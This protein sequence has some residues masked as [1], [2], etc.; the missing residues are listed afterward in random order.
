MS[1][2]V[3]NTL[4]QK[5]SLGPA[6]VSSE[7]PNGRQTVGDGA[8]FLD[9][10][11]AVCHVQ[12]ADD[13]Y[14]YSTTF[15]GGPGVRSSGCV[16]GSPASSFF[17]SSPL[18]ASGQARFYHPNI[19]AD[20]AYPLTPESTPSEFSSSL[21][22]LA[23]PPGVASIPIPLSK[24]F[25]GPPAHNLITPPYTPEDIE[26]RRS[27]GSI[28]S[29]QS[30]A[31]LDFLTTLFPRSGLAALPHA[32][33]VSITSPALEAIWEGIVLEMPGS[34][35]TLFVHGKGAEHVKLRESI[36]ALLDLAD[37]HLECTAFVIALERSSPALGELLHS[38][39]YVGGTVVTKPPFDVDPAYVLVGIE[40]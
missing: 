16:T 20:I 30:S 39:M 26:G 38:L 11:L 27:F 29:K 17:C 3:L 24:E 9:N 22:S 1:N 21:E 28:S 14:Y 15:S 5:S 6:Y 7:S 4:K 18:P 33:S 13:I 23:L 35:R 25:T 2:I 36:V 40:I 8:S 37:E 19:H 12:G 32:K 34:Q 10:V 31:A